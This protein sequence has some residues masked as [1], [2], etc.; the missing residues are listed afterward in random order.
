LNPLFKF[1]PFLDSNFQIDTWYNSL[2]EHTFPTTFV[3]LS[4]PAAKA[5]LAHRE[6]YLEFIHADLDV[7][8]K[9]DSDSD[10]EEEVNVA[11]TQL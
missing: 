1:I 2:K 11:T 9:D 4:L 10:E 6:R 5:I 3:N 7:R 8:G